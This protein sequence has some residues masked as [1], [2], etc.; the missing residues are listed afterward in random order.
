MNKPIKIALLIA[1]YYVTAKGGLKLDAVS[2]FAALVWPP[3][4]L[5]MAA[6]LLYGTSLWP[7]VF[8]G[9]FLVNFTS[10]APLS[11]ALGMG[12][13]NALEA[14]AATYVLERY[15]K[16]HRSL[17]RLKDVVAFTLIAAVTCTLISATIGVSSLWL[18]GVITLAQY[19][20]TWT[21]WWIGNMLGALIVSPVLMT[22]V[23]N[24]RIARERR[25][26]LEATFLVALLAVVNLFVFFGMFVASHLPFQQAYLLFPLFIWSG[27]RFKQRGVAIATLGTSVVAVWGTA[28]GL[29]PFTSGLFHDNLLNLQ[30]FMG[31]LSF[32]S[33]VL[34]SVV[35]ERKRAEKKAQ[36]A[37]Q[38]RDELLGIVSHDLRNPLTAIMMSAELILR[39]NAAGPDTTQSQKH[40]EKIQTLVERMNRLITDLLEVNKFEAGSLSL[41]LKT[42]E[43]KPMVSEALE[44]FKGQASQ[45]SISLVSEVS[46]THS[47]TLCDRER[48]LQVLSNLIG[49]AIKFT[50]ENGKILVRTE[51][52]HGRIKFSIKD[53][54][55][56]I[57][58]AELPHVFDRYWQ[59]KHKAQ[60]GAG[61][62]LSIAKAI[63]EAHGGKIWVVSQVGSGS[64]FAFTIPHS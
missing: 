51:P 40:A 63:V 44:M 31:L 22:W 2:H 18:G 30:L 1:V 23:K 29:G 50:P 24:H 13:G 37:L 25:R 57:L 46:T 54:G 62:G 53:N 11:A 49:N 58:P 52:L 38:A 33:M 9:A 10:G 39:E 5:S 43:I 35:T 6:L 19:R 16:F 8:I 21:A 34:A 42:T 64:T 7:G 3:T 15:F 36:D 17:D 20:D 14:I 4:G 47:Y 28:K 26:A 45:K 32:T 59:A 41:D 60:A 27:L 12:I 55:P 61:L 56:G 48:I